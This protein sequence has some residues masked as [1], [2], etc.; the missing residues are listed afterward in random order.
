MQPRKRLKRLRAAITIQTTWHGFICYADFMFVI[1]DV[2]LMQSVAR[3][4]LRQKE[5]PR[6]GRDGGADI[7]ATL[8]ALDGLFDNNLGY[9]S[10]AERW[11]IMDQAKGVP[12]ATKRTKNGSATKILSR[13]R[14]Y[15][16]LLR[17]GVREGCCDFFISIEKICSIFLIPR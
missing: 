12:Q 15:G 2:I 4:W 14:G 1:S 5:Y 10:Y 8:H 17:D 13:W 9:C 11:A 16:H 6:Q 3:R 7:V